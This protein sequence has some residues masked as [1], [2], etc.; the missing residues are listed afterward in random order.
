MSCVFAIT[1]YKLQAADC[2]GAAS[3]PS[4]LEFIERR[5]QLR[6]EVFV[7][8][9]FLANRCE[10]S[11]FPRLQPVLKFDL[12]LL[13]A[14]DW[15][16]IEVPILHRPNHR[17]LLF[18]RNR[19]VLFLFKKLDN[20]LTAIESRS[21][22]RIQIG[23]ELRERSQLTKLREIEFD[24]AGDLLDRLDLGRRSDTTNR[25]SHG[26]CWPHTLI[27]QISLKIDLAVCNRDH[28]CGNIGRDVARLGLANRQRS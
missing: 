14:L 8:L 28:V 16:S 13:H 6:L 2:E 15:N 1:N 24:L 18:H 3:L 25:E 11:S 5:F 22:C 10:Q 20:A 23:T 26:N 9:L 21:R 19:V 12:V 7:E 17:H 27:K 4:R